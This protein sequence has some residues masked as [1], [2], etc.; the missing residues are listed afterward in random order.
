MEFQERKIECVECNRPFPFTAR[1]QAF[2]K[3]KGFT[4]PK[5]CKTCRQI[6]KEQRESKQK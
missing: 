3:D 2:Y 6:R 4:D 1:D 5:R